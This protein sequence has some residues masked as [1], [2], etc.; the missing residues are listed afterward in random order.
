MGAQVPADNQYVVRYCY[1]AYLGLV[2]CLTFN[3]FGALIAMCAIN[4]G[5]GR[6]FGFMLATVYWFAGVPGAW[7]LW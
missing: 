4:P 7:I 6:L 5:S 3:W 2:W 1:W